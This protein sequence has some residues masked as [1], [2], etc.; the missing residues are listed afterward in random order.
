MSMR[1][2]WFGKI[3]DSHVKEIFVANVQKL[4]VEGV[5]DISMVIEDKNDDKVNITIH[6]VLYIP[7][8]IVNLLSVSQMI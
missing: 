4:N 7:D 5:A 3:I 8:L 6:D 1:K 2:D